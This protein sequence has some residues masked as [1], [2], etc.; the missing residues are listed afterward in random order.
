[1]ALPEVVEFL[2]SVD[3]TG[4]TVEQ[5]PELLV[6]FGGKVA[7]P[8]ERDAGI[9]PKTQRDVFYRWLLLNNPDLASKS[10]L[11]EDYSDWSSYNLYQ[12]LLAFE[13]DLAYVT[14]AV[15]I[16][17]EAPGSIAELGAFSQIGPLRERLAVVIKSKHHRASSFIRLGPIKYLEDIDQE[18]VC[19]VSNR[20]AARFELDI[21][22][23][24][25]TLEHVIGKL[26]T[27]HAFDPARPEH[28]LLLA[29][30]AITLHEVIDFPSL[31][32]VFQHF[33]ILIDDAR[34]RQLLFILQ[35]AELIYIDKH[36]GKYWYIC[37]KRKKIWLDYR[38][39]PD[40]FNRSRAAARILET[41]KKTNDK[42]FRAHEWFVTKGGRR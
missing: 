10:L 6:L 24:F 2:S 29:L 19:V 35:K 31:E 34:L 14:A 28:Q 5:H 13:T 1:M 22:T 39:R 8:A 3:P 15:L 9:P 21:P 7:S 26:K 23:V 12:D 20:P 27:K 37:R 4:T 17:L 32:A 38:G 42:S 18:S 33:A 16:F 40:K 36:G 30:D 25:D 11:P 41:R